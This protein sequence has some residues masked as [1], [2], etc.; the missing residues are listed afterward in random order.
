L[1]H[2]G[3]KFEQTLVQNKTAAHLQENHTK[4]LAAPRRLCQSCA[5]SLFGRGMYVLGCKFNFV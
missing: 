1:E 2:C 3:N 4:L 5:L